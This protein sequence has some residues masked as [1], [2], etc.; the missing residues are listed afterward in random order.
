MLELTRPTSL[1]ADESKKGRIPPR[2]GDDIGTFLIN[3]EM[4][5]K[6]CE[7]DLAKGLIY[8]SLALDSRHPHALRLAAQVLD[9]KNSDQL[10]RIYQQLALVEPIFANLIMLANCYYKRGE[11]QLAY[12]AYSE[13]LSIAPDLTDSNKETFFE[14]YKNCGAILT[15]DGDFPGAEEFFHKAFVINPQ[16]DQ[17]LVNL[18]TLEIQMNEAKH[19]VDRFREALEINPKND[20]AWV[21]LALIHYSMGDVQLALGNVENAIELNPKN[22]T[23]VHIFANWCVKEEKIHAAIERLQN[24]VSLADYDE[25]MSL[26]LIHLMCMVNQIKAAQIECERV[27]SWNPKSEKIAE[28]YQEVQRQSE[29]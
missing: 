26:L 13:A 22:R 4:L 12:A 8:K 6:N 24:F 27:F 21:G 1:S 25:E 18:G 23:A 11:D 28:I 3:A 2:H 16:S 5:I 20:K 14:I 17:L 19:A 9:P 29:I 7:V 15:R 10:I